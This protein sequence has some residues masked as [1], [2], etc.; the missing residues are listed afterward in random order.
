MGSC[1]SNDMSVLSSSLIHRYSHCVFLYF[2]FFCNVKEIGM[3]GVQQHEVRRKAK[4]VD[5]CALEW[6]ALK[7]FLAFYNFLQFFFFFGRVRNLLV[8]FFLLGVL[9]I[10]ITATVVLVV[11]FLLSV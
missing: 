10:I 9:Y 6:Y 3:K 7:S 4:G 8:F 2:F 1:N 5:P 11:D